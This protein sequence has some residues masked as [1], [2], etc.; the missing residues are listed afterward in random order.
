VLAGDIGSGKSALA[1]GVALRAARGGTPTLLLSGEM[2]EE[3]LRERALAI[4]GKATI[5]DLRQGRLDDLTRAAVGAAALAQRHLP[6]LLQPLVGPGFDEIESALEPLPRRG[7]AVVDYLQLLGERDSLAQGA[8]RA[9][10]PRLARRR[11]A[12]RAPRR[13]A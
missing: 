8:G 3:R 12:A 10:E 7:F 5:D 11:P 13:P 2:G 6:L 4:E 9:P 1:L